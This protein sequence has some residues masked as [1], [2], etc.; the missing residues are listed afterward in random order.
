VEA[1]QLQLA[2]AQD[3]VKQYQA[4]RAQADAAVRAARAKSAAIEHSLALEQGFLDRGLSNKNRLDAARAQLDAANFLVEVEQNKI[5]EL[6][7]TEPEM[8]VNLARIQ[9]SRSQSQLERARRERGEYILHAPVSGLVLR[10]QA[11]E[12]DLLGPTSSRPAV[13]LSPEGAWIVRAEVSQEFAGLVKEGLT[14]QI[15]DEANAQLL[16]DGTI[17]E[18]SDWFLPR[19]QL[20]LLPTSVNTGLTMDCVVEIKNGHAQLR[21]GQH[22]RVRVLADYRAG[23]L[24]KTV[25]H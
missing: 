15:E 1:A 25:S 5:A 18:T 21:L 24:N 9:V 12:G 10:V 17:T 22:V 4:K 3:G 2:K 11:Q 13:W 8:E 6:Q 19:R 23:T 16:G 14:V 7:A 20:N